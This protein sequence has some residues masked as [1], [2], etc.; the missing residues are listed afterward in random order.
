MKGFIQMGI[1]KRTGSESSESSILSLRIPREMKEGLMSLA[2]ATHRNQSEI[3]I[4]M[5]RERLE[6]E[7]WQIAL[8][9]KGIEEADNHL[10]ASQEEINR[11][12]SKWIKD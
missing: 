5:I 12:Y 3:A 9:E 1:K 2:E 4:E 11:I 7:S 6:I 10:F 8:V